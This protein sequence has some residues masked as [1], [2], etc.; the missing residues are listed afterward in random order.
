[1]K[2]YNSHGS[3]VPLGA[4][5]GRGGEGSVFELPSHPELV[6]KLYHQ[7]VPVEKAAKLCTM[8]QL[9][10]ERLLKLSA[11]PVDLL[12]DRPGGALKGFTMPRVGGHDIQIL[13]GPKSRIANFESASWAFLLHTAA[14]LARAV[15][16]VHEHGHVIG[17]INHGSFRIGKDAMVKLVDCDSIQLAAQ[18]KLYLCEVGIPTH[19]PAELQGKPFRGVVRT[20]N[21]DAFGLA[22][23]VFQIL[24]MG[25]H[26]FSGGFLGH[27]DMPLEKAIREFRFAYGPQ[28]ST[29]QMRQP[30]A[31]LDLLAASQGV[32]TLFER[33]FSAQGAQPD[34]RPLPREWIGALD[35]LTRQL[36]QCTISPT[37]QYL[38]TLPKCPWCEIETLSG[39]VL[40]RVQAVKGQTAAAT[41]HLDTIWKQVAA[42]PTPGPLPP[43]PVSQVAP[44]PLARKRRTHE[45]ISLGV[46][47]GIGLAILI[48]MII[49]GGITGAIC[50]L[51]AL[52]I[53]GQGIYATITEPARKVVRQALE[54]KKKDWKSVNDRWERDA[55]DARFQAKL[56]ELAGYRAEHQALPD[57]RQTRLQ[58]LEA[59]RAERQ[60]RKYLDRYPIDGAGINGIGPGRTAML[61]SYGIETAADVS[62]HAVLQAPG[63][64]LT[65]AT[66]LVHW[67]QRLERGFRFNPALGV[68][69]ADI[70]ALDAKIA[71][72]RTKLEQELRNGVPALRQIAQQTLAARNTLRPHVEQALLALRQA[73]VDL[74]GA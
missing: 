56:Q 7:N 32:A 35:A 21:H 19:T 57:L 2:V 17:D 4:Q 42:V 34:G 51:L 18:D 48:P 74:L 27:G 29:C 16:A 71:A 59:Q 66:R 60:L 14:N 31:T 28:A 68:N 5:L 69:P 1:M 37:H 9:R 53:V 11:W 30:P 67:R 25:R 49:A 33:A 6:A 61:R 23:L 43:L 46:M 65:F 39:I 22:V 73:E 12:L 10:T 26:P 63:F 55:G 44:S 72:A 13:Y 62:S 70:A 38:R 36:K 8:V 3:A 45:T 47:F 41:F 20:P 24:F 15:H 64:G 50:T 58:Q 54:E 40:F 52:A